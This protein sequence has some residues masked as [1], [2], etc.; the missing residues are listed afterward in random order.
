MV[1]VKKG[2]VLFKQNTK[3]DLNLLIS[4]MITQYYKFS[5]ELKQTLKKMFI[6]GYICLLLER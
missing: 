5:G 1:L 4:N 3:F 2:Y 6:N